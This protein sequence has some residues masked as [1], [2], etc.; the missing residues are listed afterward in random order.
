MECPNKAL[1]PGLPDELALVCLAMISHGYLGALKC[2]CKRW[3]D[4]IHSEDYASCKSRMGRCGDWLFFWNGGIENQWK[5][6]D[7]EADRWHDIPSMLRLNDD[8]HSG[9]SCVSACNR[10]LVIG[11]VYS[12]DDPEC[13]PI[14]T[15]RVLSFDPF[16]QK[17]SQVASMSTPRA[18]FACSVICGKVYVGGGC[19]SCLTTTLLSAEVYD[20]MNDRWDDL[21]TMPTL[22]TRPIPRFDWLGV[23]YNSKF[24]IL[25]HP[26]DRTMEFSPL[27]RQWCSREEMWFKPV[28]FGVQYKVLVIDGRMYAVKDEDEEKSVET[29][30]T[31]T[32]DWLHI[33]SVPPVTLPDHPP[34]RDYFDYGVCGLRNKLYIM[35]G[36]VHEMYEN[37]ARE[38]VIHFH[39]GKLR[40]VRVCDPS[41]TPLEWR[42]LRPVPGETCD[43]MLECA[44]L[45][46]QLS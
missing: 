31:Q 14:V 34:L 3:R 23:S 22:P 44:S 35:G 42:E 36:S 29:F 38:G 15:N 19:S 43:C 8:Q 25:K 26:Y 1:I 17:W 10:F 37:E 33:G 46:E 40:T 12:N 16:R 20:P 6:Y 18:D 39:F 24:Y 27:D 9:L 21:P 4:V 11:G 5:A 32:G 7:P 30:N 13:E 28:N 45:E 41:V 2:V